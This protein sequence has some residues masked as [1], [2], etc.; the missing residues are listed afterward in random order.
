MNVFIVNFDVVLYEDYKK[1]YILFQ[2]SALPHAASCKIWFSDETLEP[3]HESKSSV[4]LTLL[5]NHMLKTVGK[6]KQNKNKF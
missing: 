5:N 6:H 2:A 4:L 3:V 1:M